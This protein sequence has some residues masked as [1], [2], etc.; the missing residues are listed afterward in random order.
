MLFSYLQLGN[1][2]GDLVAFTVGSDGALRRGV[3]QEVGDSYSQLAAGS[4]Y[5]KELAYESKSPSGRPH[6]SKSLLL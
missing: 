3:T 1:S 6:L 4:T 5:H 2:D